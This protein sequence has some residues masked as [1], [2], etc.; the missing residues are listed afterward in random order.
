MV[1][2]VG[3]PSRA[4]GIRP[5]VMSSD[6]CNIYKKMKNAFRINSTT[7]FKICLNFCPLKYEYLR[8][9]D[10]EN[11]LSEHVDL[12]LA[13]IFGNFDPLVNESDPD[14]VSPNVG[15]IR[16]QI[17][18]HLFVD[19]ERRNLN[20]FVIE[21][22]ELSLKVGKERNCKFPISHYVLSI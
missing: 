14:V 18:L 8:D 5:T 17:F 20:S 19:G 7:H 2:N 16:S 21:Q 1:G 11:Y 22:A 12:F 9:K 13:A 10:K 15:P 3:T 4:L 6:L